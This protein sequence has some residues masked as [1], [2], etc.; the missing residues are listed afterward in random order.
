MDQIPLSRQKCKPC[1]GGT[2]PLDQKTAFGYLERIDGWLMNAKG[3]GIYR[4]FVMKNFMA[5]VKL[6]TAIAEKAEADDHHPDVHLTGYRNLRVELST[7]AI[8]GLSDNDFILAAKIN[9]IPCEL[10]Q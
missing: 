6:I 4:I 8:D 7:H 3:D 5:A 10:K 9:E 2:K 1:E